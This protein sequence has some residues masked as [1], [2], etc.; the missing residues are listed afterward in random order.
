[1]CHLLT[2]FPTTKEK[3]FSTTMD[4]NISIIRENKA[5]FQEFIQLQA[6]QYLC[7]YLDLMDYPNESHPLDD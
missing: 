1:M 7:S 3:L 5:F 2:N 4:L 6:H